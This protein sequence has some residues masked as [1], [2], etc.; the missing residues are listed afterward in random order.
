M[1][2]NVLDFERTPSAQEAAR[3]WV[4]RIDAGPLSQEDR[5]AL[6]AWLDADACHRHL[7]DEHALL[8]ATASRAKFPVPAA[9]P[10]PGRETWPRAGASTSWPRAMG[11][12]AIA[13]LAVGIWFGAP[14]Q[15][16][17]SQQSH[18]QLVATAVGQRAPVTLP[19]GSRTELNAASVLRVAYR[20]E[21]RRVVLERGVGLFDVTKDKLRP[22]EVVVGETIVR[23]VG[24]RFL[25]QR[26]EDGRVE[27]TV[28]EG[29]VEVIQPVSAI[30]RGNDPRASSN[31]MSQVNPQPVRLGVGQTAISQ[32]ER[33]LVSIAEPASMGHKLAWQK[34]RFEFDRT[35]LAEAVEEINRYTEHPIRLDSRSLETVL[36]SGSFSTQNTIVFL[37][38]LEQGFGL[39]VRREGE[40]WVVARP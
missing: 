28:Y 15:R 34:G 24:T 27:V 20:P 38:S 35:P 30:D 26:H 21:R 37:R 6:K 33:T 3:S 32:A 14:W 25:V 13:A 23:A 2:P 39:Q 11:A 8:W 4:V 10:L 18:D 17:T 31:P 22:F 9:S 40:A 29:V 7:L 36:V 16:F 19:D 5:L 1:N 12:L